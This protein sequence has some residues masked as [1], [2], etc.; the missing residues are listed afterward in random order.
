MK[1]GTRVRLLYCSDPHTKIARGTEGTVDFVDDTGTV[2]VTWDDG[3][4]LGM[5]PREDRFEVVGNPTANP[6]T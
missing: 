3:S 4:S 2:F 6:P 5:V 1:A